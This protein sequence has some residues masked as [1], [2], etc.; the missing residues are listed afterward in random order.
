[1]KENE[2]YINL[3]ILVNQKLYDDGVISYDAYS[4]TLD[5][6]MNGYKCNGPL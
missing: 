1:M 4:K 6:L 5:N 3:A 2:L